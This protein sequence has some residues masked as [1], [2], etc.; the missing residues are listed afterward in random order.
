MDIETNPGP[1]I[2][3]TD[4]RALDIFQLNTRSIR[5]KVDYLNTIADDY[6]IIC[7]KETHLDDSIDSA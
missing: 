6:H 2:S 4:I 1:T 3:T 7:F 5:N